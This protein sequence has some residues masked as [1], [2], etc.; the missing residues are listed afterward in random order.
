MNENEDIKN[1]VELK[2]QILNDRQKKN[3][4]EQVDR[5]AFFATEK[6]NRTNI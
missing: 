3:E 6:R 4:K 1:L 5:L 2:K